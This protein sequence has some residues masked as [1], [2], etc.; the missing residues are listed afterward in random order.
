[1]AKAKADLFELR[2]KEQ[3]LLTKYT[4]KSAPVQ[5][6]QKEI[7]LVKE[8]I[9]EQEKG[10]QDKRVTSGKNPIFQKLEMERFAALS[11]LKTFKAS[12][13]VIEEQIN[14]VDRALSNLD[15]LNKELVEFERKRGTAEENYKLYVKKV[16]EAKVSEEMDHLKMSNIGVIQAAEVPQMPAGMSMKIKLILGAIF[17]AI[18][19]LSFGFMSEYFHGGYT[20]PDQAAEDLGLPV[21]ASFSHKG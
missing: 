3:A 1:M 4:V 11:D 10:E 7:E 9:L 5:N 20:R 6:L 19:G 17:S 12:N 15:F 8:F 16:E 2:R 18:M 21:L 14:D 13:E